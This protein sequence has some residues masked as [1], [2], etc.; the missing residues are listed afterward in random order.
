VA[1]KV[2]DRMSELKTLYNDPTKNT[3]D[4]ANYDSEFSELKDQL[5]ALTGEN[6]NGVS[7][8]GSTNLVVPMTDDGSTS[9]ALTIAGRDLMST[10]TGVGVLTGS[11][12]ATLGDITIDEVTDAIQNVA[13]FRAQNGAEQSRLGF[14]SDLLTVNQANLEQATS[15][16][17]D[18]DVAAESTQLARWNVL[19]QS[20]T[21]M[22]AQANQ[23][24]QIALKLL[25]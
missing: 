3:S 6:F 18:V 25:Q 7:L 22:L 16:I 11:G 24:S 19:V 4:K 10:A 1:G 8:F 15:R 2:L 13:T 5:S 17:T 9:T 12:V 21:A 20:G 23:S 14:A